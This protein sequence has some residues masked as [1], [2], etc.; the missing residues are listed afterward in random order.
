M[1]TIFLL[2]TVLFIG[3]SVYAQVSRKTTY[4]AVSIRTEWDRKD[5]KEFYRIFADSGNPYGSDIYQLVWYHTD[6][7]ANE[8]ASFLSNKSDTATVFYNYF[9]NITEALTF[10]ADRGWELLTVNNGM[11]A[12]YSTRNSALDRELNAIPIYIF[13]KT[14]ESR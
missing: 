6:K 13:K 7:T 9:F 3:S 4:L 5:K 8:P 2:L 10:M 12:D 11:H 1:K 14:V